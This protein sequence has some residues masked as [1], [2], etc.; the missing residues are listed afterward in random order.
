[1]ITLCGAAAKSGTGC[2]A[3]Y[4]YLFGEC[5]AFLSCMELHFAERPEYNAFLSFIDP[6]FYPT[7]KL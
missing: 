3:P 2:V 7:R 1:M 6:D 4:A 5:K